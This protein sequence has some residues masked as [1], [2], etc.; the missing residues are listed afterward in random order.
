[1]KYGRYHFEV[2]G[3]Q[4]CK[5]VLKGSISCQPGRDRL[6]LV[7]AGGRVKGGTSQGTI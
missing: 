5:H 2:K 6:V 4:I 1:M 3:I 7:G